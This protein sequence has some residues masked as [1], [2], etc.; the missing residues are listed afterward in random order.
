MTEYDP[1]FALCREAEEGT[2]PNQNSSSIYKQASIPELVSDLESQILIN[3]R[4]KLKEIVDMT[5]RFSL[6]SV[7]E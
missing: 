7:Y 2:E 4:I 3:G 6:S 5:C 1:K